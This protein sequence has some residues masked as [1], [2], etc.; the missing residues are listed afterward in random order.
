MG[1]FGK[2]KFKTLFKAD[3][4][5]L[6]LHIVQQSRTSELTARAETATLPVS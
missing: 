5:K 3:P 4:E 2:I 6:E 1:P